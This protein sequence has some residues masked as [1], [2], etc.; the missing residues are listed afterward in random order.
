MNH[1]I[2]ESTLQPNKLRM[3]ISQ[4]SGS[5]E[6]DARIMH[7][8]GATAKCIL[9]CCSVGQS[10]WLEALCRFPDALSAIQTSAHT[11]RAQHTD[12]LLPPAG[13]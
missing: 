9:Q 12:T 5:P 6:I 8:L 7:N 11:P 10:L 1:E 13:P 2:D 3:P 4:S